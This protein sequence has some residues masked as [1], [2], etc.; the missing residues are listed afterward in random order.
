LCLPPYFIAIQAEGEEMRLFPT[1]LVIS[2]A[3]ASA[4][5]RMEVLVCN[6]ANLPQY[7]LTKAE[8][9]ADY[10]FRSA[11]IEVEWSGCENA[12]APPHILPRFVI[13]LRNDV[14]P[15]FT[16]ELSLHAMGRAFVSNG[17]GYIADVYYPAIQG[18]SEASEAGPASLIGY[19]IV[20]EIGHLLLGPGHRP[21]GIMRARWGQEEFLALAQRSLTFDKAD[22]TRLGDRVRRIKAGLTTH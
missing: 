6:S 3:S 20:H 17:E 4:A 5:E 15:R 8:T 19:T 12:V 10:V 7:L 22:R 16:G 21:Q 13:R 14:V 9:E 1:V 11:D 2:V 18:L